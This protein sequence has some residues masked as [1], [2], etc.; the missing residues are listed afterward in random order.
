MRNKIVALSLLLMLAVP[1]HADTKPWFKSKRFWTTF[2]LQTAAMT[3]DFVTTRQSL[4]RGGVETN[5]IYGSHPSN[6][7]LYSIGVPLEFLVAYGSYAASQDKNKAIRQIGW[8]LPSAVIGLHIRAAIHNTNV[9]PTG[10]I[11]LH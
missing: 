8:I 4:A 5:R 3:A 1:A 7:R 10:E 6:A 2:S 11:C 9:C